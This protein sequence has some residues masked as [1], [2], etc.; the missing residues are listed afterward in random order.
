MG[1][2]VIELHRPPACSGLGSQVQRS[3]VEL[4][5]PAAHGQIDQMLGAGR[6]LERLLYS[7]VDS[8]YCGT[9]ATSDERIWSA[10]VPIMVG[11]SCRC[12]FACPVIGQVCIDVGRWVE[13]LQEWE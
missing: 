5:S 9:L 8:K 13:P 11:N 6:M 4:G 10:V 1:Q 12:R 7:R 2:P 3:A